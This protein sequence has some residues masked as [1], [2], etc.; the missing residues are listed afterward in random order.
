MTYI[1]RIRVAKWRCSGSIGEAITNRFDN[2]CMFIV[3]S[4]SKFNTEQ[5]T[6]EMSYHEL[7][8]YC[9]NIKRELL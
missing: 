4:V 7:L 5:K 3:N 8:H 1:L 9:V 6:S 2:F